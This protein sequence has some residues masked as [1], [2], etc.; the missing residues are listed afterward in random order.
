[1]TKNDLHAFL[2]SFLAALG[3]SMPLNEF[4]GGLLLAIAATFLWEIWRPDQVAQGGHRT[5]VKILSSCLCAIL[6]AVIQSEIYPE[7]SAQVTMA[8]AGLLG[9]PLG[10]R[11]VAR[12]DQIADRTIDR[13]VG[14]KDKEKKE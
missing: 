3:F 8:I 1:M 12:S 14:F 10:R 4:A 7:W 5:G 6:A 11:L 2:G 13:V 9:N